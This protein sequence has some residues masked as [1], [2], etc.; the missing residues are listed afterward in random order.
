ML[1]R[2]CFVCESA[3][4]CKKIPSMWFVFFFLC[5][6]TPADVNHSRTVVLSGVL[7]GQGGFWGSLLHHHV[8]WDKWNIYSTSLNRSPLGVTAGSDEE[9]AERLLVLKCWPV[10]VCL[11]WIVC[12]G[13]GPYVFQLDQ[14]ERCGESCISR[15]FAVF[16]CR[17]KDG[18]VKLVDFHPSCASF[19][20]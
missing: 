8:L 16:L 14:T 6:Y 19:Q 18:M 17:E 9:T 2:V 3:S 7:L 11:Q 20:L 4:K 1:I 5:C 15:L 13:P 12:F 10:R